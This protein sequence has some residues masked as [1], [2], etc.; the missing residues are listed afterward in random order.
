MEINDAVRALAALAQ[1]TRLA[2]FRLL[3][4]AGDAA[5]PAGDIAEQLSVPAA[6]L[7]FHLAALRR[8]GLVSRERQ[9][10]QLLYRADQQGVR[11][12][13]A[14]LSEDCCQGQPE[15]CGLGVGPGAARSTGSGRVSAGQTRLNKGSKR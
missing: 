8:A 13:L 11:A 7:S 15:L 4:R 14:Y 9:G 10:R 2:V 3:V 1:D 6:T 5:L 12:L